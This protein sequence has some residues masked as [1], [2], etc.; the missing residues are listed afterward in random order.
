MAAVLGLGYAWY[1]RLDIADNL[2]AGKLD[3]LGLPA[4][5]RLESIGTDRQVLTNLVIGDPRQ[6]DLTVERVEV[7][8]T[9]RWGFPGIGRITLVKPRLYGRYVDGRLTFGSLDPVIFTGSKEPFRLPD[10]DVAVVDG[11]GLMETGVGP[12]GVKL[13]GKGEL[14]DGFKGVVAMTAPRI[15]LPGCRAENA[16]LFA[17]VAIT[18]EKPDIAG[19]LR[20]GSL[21]CP[22]QGLRLSQAVLGIKARIDQPFDGGEG[23]LTLASGPLGLGAARIAATSGEGR[24]TFRK[25]ALT[26]RYDLAA[27]GLEA[28]GI[29]AAALAASGM[30][31]GRDNFKRLDVDGDVTG[32]G[33][34]PGVDAD[35]AL[36]GFQRQAAGTLAEPLLARVR[37]ALQR[38][39]RASRLNGQFV[40]R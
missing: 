13:E 38:E 24:V 9:T 7:A 14:H 32:S 12:F 16:S 5:Y 18:D 35:A 6:P 19:P 10:L 26:A 27:R 31:R 25:G 34:R 3:D 15:V 8:T 1:A 30:V 37:P 23:V 2:I 33:I 20:L 11:R 17:Q 36:A 39:V 22:D 4:T 29:S 21:S 28:G 40:L